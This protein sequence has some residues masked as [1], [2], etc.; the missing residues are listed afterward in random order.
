MFLEQ[1]G[2]GGGRIAYSA[3]DCINIHSFINDDHNV[4]PT[5]TIRFSCLNQDILSRT[6]ILPEP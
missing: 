2:V 4:S 5:F 1:F 3:S 6:D